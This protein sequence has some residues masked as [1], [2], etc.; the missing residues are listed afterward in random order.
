MGLKGKPQRTTVGDSERHRKT[1]IQKDHKKTEHRNT[2]ENH[3]YI[4]RY[5]KTC[6]K[7]LRKRGR[8]DT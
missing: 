4:G 8:I 3:R 7:P 1:H 2:T 5:T 6:K